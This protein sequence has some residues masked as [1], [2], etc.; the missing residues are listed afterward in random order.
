M[1]QQLRERKHQVFLADS[2]VLN[3]P[4]FE[5]YAAA[6]KPGQHA[7][8]DA[9]MEHVPGAD[10][11]LVVSAEYNHNVPPAL[12]NMLCHFKP[13]LAFKPAGICTYSAGP[14]GGVRVVGP[15]RRYALLFS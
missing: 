6:Y 3:L 12:G 8:I 13:E 11:H 7:G 15:L 2:Q 14:W 4:L 5:Q 9:L 10:A 1:A